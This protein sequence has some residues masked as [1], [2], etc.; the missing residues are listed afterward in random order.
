MGALFSQPSGTAVNHKL[1]LG[2][3]PCWTGWAGCAGDSELYGAPL[4]VLANKQ[5]LA[6]S[7][8]ACD[9]AEQL[10]ISNIA[11]RPCNVQ[12][13]SAITGDGLKAA[14]QWIVERVRKSQ[15]AELLRR[16]VLMG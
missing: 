2:W 6:G 3:S 10:E 16:K 14:V 12:S 1:E 4:L 7:V 9:V 15:R 11:A 13:V 8:A 5:D